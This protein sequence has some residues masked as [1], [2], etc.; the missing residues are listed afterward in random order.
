[1]PKGVYVRR[2]GK[3]TKAKPLRFTD[4]VVADNLP[5]IRTIP[6]QDVSVGDLGDLIRKGAVV[7]TVE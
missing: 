2:R 3:N 7:V 6:I 1:M 4:T 5:R